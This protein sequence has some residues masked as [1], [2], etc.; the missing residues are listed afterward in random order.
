VFIEIKLCT[1]FDV[2][3]QTSKHSLASYIFVRCVIERVR[4]K[5]R[6]VLEVYGKDQRTKNI[7]KL[8][9]MALLVN[10]AMQ[11]K[12]AILCF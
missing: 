2:A 9:Y 5:N 12:S 3:C 8:F 11:T 10:L 7:K 4:E 6:K 1:K